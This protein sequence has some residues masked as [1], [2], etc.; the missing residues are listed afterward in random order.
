MSITQVTATAHPQGSRIDIHWQDSTQRYAGVGIA[1][2]SDRYPE[3]LQDS[4]LRD[5]GD[6]PVYWLVSNANTFIDREA[7]PEKPY[8]YTL[9]PFRES[10]SE[11]EDSAKVSVSGMATAD[12]GFNHYLQDLL[13]AIYQRYDHDTGLLSRF[14]ELLSS[15][16]NS[17]YSYASFARKVNHIDSAPG[18]MLP[19]LAEWIGWQLDY[20]RSIKSQR[21][22]IKQA[23]S[24]YQ[25]VGLIP[26][27]EAM[28]KRATSLENR[29]KEFVH[30]IFRSNNPA[31]NNLWQITRNDDE[32]WDSVDG[33]QLEKLVSLD[34][35]FEGNAS[36]CQDETGGA[37][38]FYHTQRGQ[39]WEIWYKRSSHQEIP[40]ELLTDLEQSQ[41]TSRLLGELHQRGLTFIEQ[42]SPIETVHG[43][44]FLVGESPNQILIEQG[45]E[46][47]EAY[48]LRLESRFNFGP[49]QPLSS[50]E[51][52]Q[53]NPTVLAH[54]NMLWVVWSVYDAETARWSLRFRVRENASWNM[55]M[56]FV[57]GSGDEDV[58]TQRRDPKLLLIGN[59]LWLFWFESDDGIDWFISFS[60]Y[61]SD[62]W[63][64]PMRAVISE[65][66]EAHS[67]VL[68][69]DLSVVERNG[70][71]YLAWTSNQE[72]PNFNP[73]PINT[74][75]AVVVPPLNRRGIKLLVKETSEYSAGGFTDLQFIPRTGDSNYHDVEPTLVAEETRVG[76]Y[77]STNRSNT[78]WS[79]WYL[80]YNDEFFSPFRRVSGSLHSQ[81]NPLPVIEQQAGFE[82]EL[83]ALIYRSNRPVPYQS[84]SYRP[85]ETEDFRYSGS[86]ALDIRHQVEIRREFGSLNTDEAGV[87][88]NTPAHTRADA[89]AYTYEGINNNLSHEDVIRRDTV[90]SY[91]EGLDDSEIDPANTNLYSMLEGFIGI[92]NRVVLKPLEENTL[93]PP[94]EENP[95]LQEPDEGDEQ[96]VPFNFAIAYGGPIASAAPRPVFAGNGLQNT[97]TFRYFEAREGRYRLFSQIQVN[98][99]AIGRNDLFT[100]QWNLDQ[101]NPENTQVGRVLP[102]QDWTLIEA[103]TDTNNGTEISILLPVRWVQQGAF[104]VAGMEV[105]LMLRIELEIEGESQFQETSKVFRIL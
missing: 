98:G 80:G 46:T 18:E 81:R 103:A 90:V 39:R 93:L 63:Q 15:E 21:Q 17:I 69:K 66:G 97:F 52:I 92:N 87:S 32:E 58:V 4:D 76:I 35:N 99:E 42:D 54:D 8:Y 53:K 78:G 75:E 16:M 45:L 64:A 24:I 47:L 14:I 12:N 34:F 56:P 68:P 71:I 44:S 27:L 95:E 96:S 84:T 1:R 86:R 29:S 70:R 94:G 41:L 79:I 25:R 65:G 19:L 74:P 60:Q 104:P 55:E 49:S 57:I 59:Y 48:D 100:N 91:L 101:S 6:N 61:N 20:Q 37:W 26:T 51:Q 50:G 11:L 5:S 3:T 67:E 7:C 38:L 40:K 9:F 73:Y 62:T 31:I 23:P 85:T 83:K 2:R 89:F 72:V 13:P 36:L 82:R 102:L 10:E 43:N 77:F 28:V 22:A 33:E 88:G 105:T 30:N